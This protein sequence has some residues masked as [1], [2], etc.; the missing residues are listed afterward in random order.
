MKERSLK[1]WQIWKVKD[2]AI[3]CSVE[4]QTKQKFS[5]GRSILQSITRWFQYI[6]KKLQNSIEIFKC[7]VKI[8]NFSMAWKFVSPFV[9]LISCICKFLNIF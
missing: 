6:Y 3:I 8:F 4:V 9:L 5:R 2:K 7:K 1:F